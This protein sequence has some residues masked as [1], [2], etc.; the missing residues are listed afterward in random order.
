MNSNYQAGHKM[1]GQI[2]LNKP[3][4]QSLGRRG[5]AQSRL[6]LPGA[7]LPVSAETGRARPPATEKEHARQAIS[8]ARSMAGAKSSRERKRRGHLVCQHLLCMLEGD[9]RAKTG[10]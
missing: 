2:K 9:K 4:G 3:A 6:P 8:L 1:Y 7:R 10:S 5:P